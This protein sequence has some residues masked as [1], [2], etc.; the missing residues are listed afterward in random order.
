MLF[1]SLP[2]PFHSCHWGLAPNSLIT[3]NRA[4]ISQRIQTGYSTH[5]SQ[6][7]PITVKAIAFKGEERR[8]KQTKANFGQK[9]E[10][11]GRQSKK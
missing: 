6:H 3:S 7:L 1:L 5:L 2:V 10:E 8:R 11:C 9:A 4:L